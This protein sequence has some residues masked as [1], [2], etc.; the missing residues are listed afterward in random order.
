MLYFADIKVF[1]EELHSEI[2][3]IEL[4]DGLPCKWTYPL[5][6]PKLLKRVEGFLK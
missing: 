6:Q 4:F 5:I 2:E 3:R 1:E